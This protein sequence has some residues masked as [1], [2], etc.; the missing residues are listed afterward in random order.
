MKKLFAKLIGKVF[1]SYN[2]KGVDV[3]NSVGFK[4]NIDWKT[5]NKIVFVDYFEEY[6]GYFLTEE[7]MDKV[8]YNDIYVDCNQNIV[9]I[10]TGGAPT[11]K[12]NT[13]K[14]FS[15][16]FGTTLV[17][18]V[19]LVEYNDN[20]TKNLYA[21][22]YKKSELISLLSEIE[23]YISKDKIYNESRVEGFGFIAEL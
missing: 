15:R 16:K 3:E 9:K 22:H 7:Y 13:S 5:V 18:N 4:G 8:L 11:I 20:N 12:K 1:L 2:D 6:S 21:V 19:A 10:R 23:N 17:N 14:P